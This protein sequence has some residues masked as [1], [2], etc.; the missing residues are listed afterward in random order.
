MFTNITWT[1]YII[2]VILL[3]AIYY[4]FIGIR[5]YYPE[6]KKLAGKRRSQLR[7]VH[8]E[9][10]DEP[11]TNNEYEQVHTE[12][13]T[14]HNSFA[15]TPDDTFQEVEHLIGRLKEAIEEASREK[16]SKQGFSL[17]LKSVLKEC[18]AIK[19][20]PF[21]SAI[22]ELIISECA[23]HGPIMPSGDEAVMLWDDV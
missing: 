14:T 22:N 17:Y 5:F 19:N 6:L 8:D 7:P 9:L 1:N 2:V 13:F 18:P 20:S 12:Q 15:E 4:L 21:R 23:R 10:S 16:H 3:L 11:D